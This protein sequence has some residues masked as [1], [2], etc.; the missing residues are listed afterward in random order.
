MSLDNFI[1]PVP[2][3]YTPN[4]GSIFPETVNRLVPNKNPSG[5]RTGFSLNE[6]INKN[7][8]RE[9]LAKILNVNPKN[10]YDLSIVTA[11]KISKIS[12][13]P[14][15]ND[16]L[17]VAQLEKS[18]NLLFKPVKLPCNSECASLKAPVRLA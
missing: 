14:K 9:V 8:I 17:V 5:D 15:M 4:I 7:Y 11:L 18:K 16:G 2:I 3:D 1:K 6:S 13:E 12:L 10:V